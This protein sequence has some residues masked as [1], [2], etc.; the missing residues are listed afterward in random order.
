MEKY[1]STWKDTDAK[2]T[3]DLDRND[4]LAFKSFHIFSILAHVM[5][6]T[7]SKTESIKT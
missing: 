3:W 5:I 6:S 4:T 7:T 1:V 2:E